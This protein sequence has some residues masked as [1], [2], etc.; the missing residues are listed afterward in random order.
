MTTPPECPDLDGNSTHGAGSYFVKNVI[1]AF[2]N[3]E[4]EFL[5]PQFIWTTT[6]P[7]LQK[8]EMVQG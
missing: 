4:V 8:L 3:P 1:L 6:Q 2:L 5:M 7:G